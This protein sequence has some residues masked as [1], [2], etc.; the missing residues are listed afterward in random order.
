MSIHKDWEKEARQTKKRA[1][2]NFKNITTRATRKITL[3]IEKELGLLF[4][5][6]GKASGG[7]T[8]QETVY[9]EWLNGSG[10]NASGISHSYSQGT[11]L[12]QASMSSFMGEATPKMMKLYTDDVGH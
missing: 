2:R 10:S 1:E 4:T 7:I 8:S 12:K 5:F 9:L 11:P 3:Q 6:S